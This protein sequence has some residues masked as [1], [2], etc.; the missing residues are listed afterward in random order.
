MGSEV[1]PPALPDALALNLLLPSN[2][3]AGYL[4]MGKQ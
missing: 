2:R 4:H 3:A 1:S